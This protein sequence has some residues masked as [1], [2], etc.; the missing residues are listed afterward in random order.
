MFL[1]N[2]L[3]GQDWTETA[4]TQ[5]FI[6]KILLVFFS[7]EEEKQKQLTYDRCRTA[8]TSNYS[9]RKGL[10]EDHPLYMINLCC[11]QASLLFPFKFCFGKLSM[12]FLKPFMLL[13]SLAQHCR[14]PGVERTLLCHGSLRSGR[15]TAAEQRYKGHLLMKESGSSDSGIPFAS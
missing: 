11:S 3:E 12:F 1:I 14:V 15:D 7:R 9:F 4:M 2:L 10:R 13:L 5:N 6:K 8:L